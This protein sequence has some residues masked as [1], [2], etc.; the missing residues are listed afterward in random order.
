MSDQADGLRQ[1]VQARSGASALAE[2]PAAPA[3]QAGPRAR[4][5]VLTSGKGGVGTSNLALNLAIALGE[6]GGGSCWSTPTSAWRTSTCSAAWRPACDLGD[7]L[8]GEPA[9]GRGDRRRARPGSGSSPGAHG[10]RTL[11][12]ALGDA[13]GGWSRSCRG[14][15]RGRLPGRRRRLGPGPVDRRRWR[16]R[17]TRCWSSPRPSR[18]RWPTPTPRSTGSAAWPRRRR[19]GRWSTRPARPPRPPRSSPGC[20]ASSRQF[21]GAVVTALG[22]VR[23]DPHV[24]LAVR[25]RRPF[26]DGLSR[27]RRLARRPAAG[28]RRWSSATG[29]RAGR[30]APA[31]SPRWPPA[32]PW[33]GSPADRIGPT[34]DR[35]AI[36]SVADRSSAIIRRCG[37]SRPC[38]L[39]DKESDHG[40]L[41][42]REDEGGPSA[43]G[44]GP[45]RAAR[46]A[47]PAR[48][49]G[50]PRPPAPKHRTCRLSSR[51]HGGQG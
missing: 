14:W 37:S 23:S 26:V 19:S 25:A 17:P 27:R 39:S 1:L 47:G 15:R 21:F 6:R 43:S 30:G 4:S 44:R 2:P 22:Y 34:V 41:G 33:A 7:V 12:E 11:V 3:P 38:R 13:P 32:G 36:G 42:P 28:P 35:A 46:R 51:R 16:R 5:L 50:S 31:S 24:P 45:G 49:G 18:P 29:A 48:A 40:F 10:S 20:R 9:A 8:A